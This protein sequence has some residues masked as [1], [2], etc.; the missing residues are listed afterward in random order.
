MLD[1]NFPSFFLDKKRGK[2]I[3]AVIIFLEK[4]IGPRPAGKTR[5]TQTVASRKARAAIIFLRKMI[6]AASGS[7]GELIYSVNRNPNI[8]ELNFKALRLV[9]SNLSTKA[10]K[11]PEVC[12]PQHLNG[13]QAF[14][15]GH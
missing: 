14:N 13:H 1:Q 7:M 11:S 8:F 5:C 2:K 12:A 6:K 15:F 10:G 9:R 3:K 4:L